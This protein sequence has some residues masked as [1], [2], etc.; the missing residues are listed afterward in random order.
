MSS[1]YNQLSLGFVE[2]QQPLILSK[3][4]TGN[5]SLQRKYCSHCAYP[6]KT[7]VCSAVTRLKLPCKVTIVQDRREAKHA[8]NTARLCTLLSDDIHIVDS[9]GEVTQEALEQ[10]RQ[11]VHDDGRSLNIPLLIYPNPSSQSLSTLK[12]E[13]SNQVPNKEALL[14]ESEAY[15]SAKSNVEYA[16]PEPSIST[17]LKEKNKRKTHLIFIDASWKQ[18]FHVYKSLDVLRALPSYHLAQVPKS[19]YRIRK[20]SSELKLSTLEAIAYTLEYLFDVPPAPFFDVMEKMQSHW[21]N[22]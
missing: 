8:K 21:P 17:L 6:S 16:N 18:A 19:R 14:F 15:M 2:N 22:H 9:D 12:R 13:H 7:C 4:L 10:L 3:K 20:T 11:S 5:Q 1:F